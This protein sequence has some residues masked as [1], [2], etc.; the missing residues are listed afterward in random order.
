[1]LAEQYLFTASEYAHL[2]FIDEM[3][4]GE[5]DCDTHARLASYY[6]RGEGAANGN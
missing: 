6:E 4:G 1:M 2:E 3:S 5:C